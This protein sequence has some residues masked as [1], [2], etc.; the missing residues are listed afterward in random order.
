MDLL[1]KSNARFQCFR[2]ALSSESSVIVVPGVRKLVGR[3]ANS[4]VWSVTSSERGAVAVK[5]VRM[6][7]DDEEASA[8]RELE[9]LQRLCN[10]S[11]NNLIHFLGATTNEM[12]GV[13]AFYLT[14]YPGTLQQVLDMRAS[15]ASGPLSTGETVWAGRCITLAL[16]ALHTAGYCHGDLRPANVMVA[17]HGLVLGDFGLSAQVGPAAVPLTPVPAGAALY[18]APESLLSQASGG[19]RGDVWALGV[20]L[21]TCVDAHPVLE[22]LHRRI[23][24]APKDQAAGRSAVGSE[25]AISLESDLWALSE[26]VDDLHAGASALLAAVESNGL[27]YPR[28][29]VIWKSISGCVRVS[30]WE[31]SPLSGLL[32]AFGDVSASPIP[33]H[34]AFSDPFE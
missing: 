28:Q 14:L 16:T 7:S 18:C 24:P 12:S 15:A 5:E 34:A 6:S 10:A 3:G 33:F 13:A 17:A 8:L 22:R 11:N 23:L 32:A 25:R 26:A 4:R 19:L 1:Q 29:S 2:D 27:D 20:L 30:P 21:W 31:R 9:V